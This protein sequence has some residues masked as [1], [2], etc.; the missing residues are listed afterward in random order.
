MMNIRVLIF[1]F[2]LFG[3]GFCQARQ[4]APINYNQARIV[5]VE[6]A[7]N[8][9]ELRSAGATVVR[10]LQKMFA[11]YG[12]SF[13]DKP[14]KQF[15]HSKAIYFGNQVQPGDFMFFSAPKPGDLDIKDGFVYLGD[16]SWLNI[17]SQG[18]L[19]SSVDLI[20]SSIINYDHSQLVSSG[21]AK[22][23]FLFFGSYLGVAEKIVPKDLVKVSYT[24]LKMRSISINSEEKYDEKDFVEITKINPN[25]RYELLY[26]TRH[27]LANDT[28]YPSA[29]CYAR[30]ALAKRLDLVQ[31]EV[32]KKGLS[33]KITDCY[34]PRSAQAILFNACSVPGLVANPKKG[35]KHNRGAAVDVTLVRLSDEQ[36]LDMGC[37]VD[38]MSERSFRSYAVSLTKEHI[39]NRKLLEDV[40]VKH[41]FNALPTE[42]WHFDLKN[43]HDFPLEDKTFEE[44]AVA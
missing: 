31:Q 11:H 19:K 14:H 1:L 26:A 4:N 10:L 8:C 22:D 27:N 44:L 41:G 35:S 36:E 23:K 40:M 3:G 42:W 16:N 7:R 24:P 17:N 32:E 43:W 38:E 37:P 5:V 34:R 28:I 29:Q 39:A 9:M 20:G 18:A 25:I 15:L 30:Y 33:L 21:E 13:S 2:L 6:T 12:I